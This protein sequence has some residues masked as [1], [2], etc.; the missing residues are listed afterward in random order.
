MLQYYNHS[1]EENQMEDTI[2]NH[3]EWMENWKQ[4]KRFIWVYCTLVNI[5]KAGSKALVAT[6]YAHCNK[7]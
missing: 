5:S 1:N 4:S 7:I 3:W 6:N 2:G